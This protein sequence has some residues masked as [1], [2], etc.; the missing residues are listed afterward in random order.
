MVRQRKMGAFGEE[1]AA[2]TTAVEALVQAILGADKASLEGLVADQLS[3]GHWSGVI[4]N[5][6]QFID[7]I[8]DK[9][10]IYK[11]IQLSDPSIVVVGDKAIV[12]HTFSNITETGGKSI[13]ISLGVL[14]VWTKQDGAWRLLAR[15]GFKLPS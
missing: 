1:E 9:K 2:V 6:A 4:E 15:Q 3:Y 5:K 7:V 10:T 8:A 12:R 11:T 13:S 14:Q